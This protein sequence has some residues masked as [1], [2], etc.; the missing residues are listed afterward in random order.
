MALDFQRIKNVHLA[1]KSSA[2]L[3]K[4]EPDFYEQLAKFL[5]EER[6][7]FYE[8][9]EKSADNLDP[10]DVY[11]YKN[12]S[13]IVREIILMRSEKVVRRAVQEVNSPASSEN[14]VDWEKELYWH[15]RKE[16]ES[17][18]SSVVGEGSHLNLVRV[19]IL[20]DIPM[21]VGP[22]LKEYGPYRMGEEV[23]LPRE[24]AELLKSKGQAEVI[25]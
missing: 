23:P 2:D 13:T 17:R 20:T 10:A 8:M 18:L 14:M 5:Q 7:K 6:K 3:S 15:V 24:V 25:E 22:D 12:L 21:F 16:V 19:R 1:E 11:Y 4:V 9:V